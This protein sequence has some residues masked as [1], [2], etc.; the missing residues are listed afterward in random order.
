MN[1][2]ENEGAAALYAFA[3]QLET[4]AAA[5]RR[6]L[7]RGAERS[8]T[9]EALLQAASMARQMAYQTERKGLA[10]AMRNVPQLPE[11]DALA[12]AVEAA[13]IE[14][15]RSIHGR[16]PQP[17]EFQHHQALA[18]RNAVLAAWPHLRTAAPKPEA[19]A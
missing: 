19:N 6:V 11:G 12:R 2:A 7:Q 4:E 9:V 15:F 3:R 10:A 17:S 18:M 1:R 5:Y 13:R 16:E 8:T 14:W